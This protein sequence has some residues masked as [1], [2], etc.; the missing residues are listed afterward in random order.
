MKAIIYKFMLLALLPSL[1][2]SIGYNRTV[3][4]LPHGSV[5]QAG[6]AF[7]EKSDFGGRTVEDL[8]FLRIRGRL[9]EKMP[10][11]NRLQSPA[12]HLPG[13]VSSGYALNNHVT[14]FFCSQREDLQLLNIPIHLFNRVFL[15]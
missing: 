11:F 13:I 14:V 10:D 7:Q 6:I 9:T 12:R 4:A 8:S 5:K 3:T 1:V 2:W 15:I